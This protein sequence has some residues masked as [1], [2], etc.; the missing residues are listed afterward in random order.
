[1]RLVGWFTGDD[2][3]AQ[4]KLHTD[5]I[6]V[7]FNGNDNGETIDEKLEEQIRVDSLKAE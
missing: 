1:M 2:A 5:T 6:E 3:V 4:T 7:N